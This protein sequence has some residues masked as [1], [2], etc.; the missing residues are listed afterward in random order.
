[1][2]ILCFFTG[3]KPYIVIAVS[4]GLLYVLQA[5]L[6]ISLRLSLTC[7]GGTERIFNNVTFEELK[8]VTNDRDKLVQKL[9]QYDMQL[10]GLRREKDELQTKLNH[11]DHYLKQ[12]WI[13]FS[14]SF[15]Y[16]STTEKSWQSSRD[17]CLGRGADLITIDSREENASAHGF[18]NVRVLS[19]S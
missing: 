1:M 4:V 9:E 11:F 10:T 7:S 2:D 17:D 14:G 5:V 6:N 8:N 3:K 16:I 13:H 12:N 19:K 15:Y 18:I